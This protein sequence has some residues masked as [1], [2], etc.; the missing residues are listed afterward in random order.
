MCLFMSMGVNTALVS[1][2]PMKKY[3]S[4]SLEFERAIPSHDSSHPVSEI[5]QVAVLSVITGA[6]F[7]KNRLRQDTI[8]DGQ[9]YGGLLCKLLLPLHC[10]CCLR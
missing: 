1:I 9:M 3:D 2:R 7:W 6:F 8:A 4:Q 10:S 5:L